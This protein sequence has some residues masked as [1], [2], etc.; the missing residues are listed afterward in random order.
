[1]IAC[2]V[3]C[4]IDDGE[5][6]AERLR[7]GR[8]SCG[9]RRLLAEPEQC[10]FKT[11]AVVER[12]RAIEPQMRWAAAGTGR[13]LVS[14]CSIRRR[15]RAV[16]DDDRRAVIAATEGDTGNVEFEACV[17]IKMLA[18]VPARSFTGRRILFKLRRR[19][20]KPH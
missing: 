8:K 20:E 14:I 2:F 12:A 17:V 10:E 6:H 5:R 3:V 16:G 1:E 11:E 15:Y 9:G 4:N 19:N 13:W 18:R 7:G